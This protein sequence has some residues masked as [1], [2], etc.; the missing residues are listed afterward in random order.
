MNKIFEKKVVE[1]LIHISGDL[2]NIGLILGA[3]TGTQKEKDDLQQMMNER[4]AVRRKV[5]KKFFDEYDKEEIQSFPP[6]EKYKDG[7][8]DP[9]TKEIF[10]E[11]IDDDAYG[12]LEEEVEK[13]KADI[14][15][16]NEAKEDLRGIT[17]RAINEKMELQKKIKELEK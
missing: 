5:I 6:V 2:N 3:Y 10:K 12:K 15:K 1:A 11:S 7:D 13:L 14:K 9:N 4:G 17:Q 16:L 8:V